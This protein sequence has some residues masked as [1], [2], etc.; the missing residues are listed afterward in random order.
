MHGQERRDQ[1]G[2]GSDPA[3]RAEHHRRGHSGPGQGQAV[4]R[5]RR[6]PAQ[7]E[8]QQDL[9]APLVDQEQPGVV[10][11]PRRR[12]A[13]STC[14][15]PT[16]I[17][18][19]T[20]TSRTSSWR[21][22]ATAARPSA[23][24]TR[25]RSGGQANQGTSSAIDP[26]TGAVYIVWRGFSPNAILMSK[27]T[28]GG[29]V[30]EQ[31]DHSSRQGSIRTTRA[32]RAC[33]SARSTSRAWP[34]R[35]TRTA[36]VASTSRGRSARSRL[37]RRRRPTRARRPT[38]AD[39]DARIVVATSTNGGTTF[40]APM[41][42]D[43]AYTVN[44]LQPNGSPAY[45]HSRGHQ[46]QASLTFAAGKLLA[47]WLDQR[48][49][50]TQG[51]LVCP[52]AQ[53]WV[54]ECE[55]AGRGAPRRQ[56]TPTSMRPATSTSRSRRC[57]RCRRRRRPRSTT[58]T[59]RTAVWTT[60]MT[61][62]SPGLVRRHT[63]DA[64]TAMA[65]P[66]DSPLFAS[67]RV[68]QYTFGNTAQDRAG[69]LRDRAEGSQSAEPGDVLERDR[70]RSSATTSTRRASSSW[71]PATPAQPYKF[72]AG[73]TTNGAFVTG[74][75]APA[76]H[77]AFTDNRDVIPPLS[78]DWTT[79]TCQTTDFTKDASGNITGVKVRHDLR[80]RLRRQSQP[81]RLL[82]PPSPRTPSRSPARTRSCWIRLPRAAS[83]SRCAT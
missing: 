8:R 28:D 64:Y 21:P 35:S 22:R 7:L 1:V 70:R 60:Y 53:P 18:R 3:R 47:T 80:P 48:E 73:V 45:S 63:L 9:R 62:G 55:R 6:R 17:S 14:T 41:A 43:D 13:R 2:R 56:G 59:T 29:S 11:P 71:R 19:A 31:T 78:G 69:H 30:V 26:L 20:A 4:D 23:S 38:P 39:C 68:S 75:F 42:V 10:T 77:V 33:R 66:A 54:H 67:S 65:D 15:S 83:S 76:F 81:E 32:R 49:D 57:R 36:R 74:G 34:C 44:V 79:P 16:P 40:G 24:R 72:N 51:V 27:S 46:M 52:A 5:G 58:A 12:S 37:R 50:H 82:R 61:D 25:Y